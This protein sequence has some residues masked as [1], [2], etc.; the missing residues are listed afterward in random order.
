MGK[1]KKNWNTPYPDEYQD[2]DEVFSLISIK[3]FYYGTTYSYR[4][5]RS[6]RHLGHKSI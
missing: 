2:Q 6:H 3:T 5:N 1:D 4:Y